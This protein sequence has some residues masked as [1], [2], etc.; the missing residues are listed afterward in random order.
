MDNRR[1][2]NPFNNILKEK[3]N[4][5]RTITIDKEITQKRVGQDKDMSDSSTEELNK[6]NQDFK[7]GQKIQQLNMEKIDETTE[8]LQIKQSKNSDIDIVMTC[9]SIQY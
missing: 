6:T 7:I 5:L 2:E 4:M 3:P 8:N 9:M 1:T